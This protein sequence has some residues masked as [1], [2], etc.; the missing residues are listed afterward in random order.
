MVASLVT[1][2]FLFFFNDR[3]QTS[4]KMGNFTAEASDIITISTQFS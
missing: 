1:R 4:T 3:N 2:M